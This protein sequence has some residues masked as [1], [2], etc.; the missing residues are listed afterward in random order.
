MLDDRLPGGA[1]ARRDGKGEPWAE[2][3]RLLGAG[4]QMLDLDAVEFEPDNVENRGKLVRTH[5]I[6]AFLER[7]ASL[8]A[9]RASHVTVS[10]YLCLA[11]I[12]ANWQPYPPRFFFVIGGAAPPWTLQELDIATGK[13]IAP[14]WCVPA[15]NVPE[16]QAKEALHQALAKV[17]RDSGIYDL[18]VR[19]REWLMMQDRN[20]V[21]P[22]KKWI[23]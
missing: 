11:R 16:A 19:L 1:K 17:W 5:A 15:L 3:H 22:S 8:D 10:V 18:R 6:V 12:V 20:F 4:W 7:K 13:E 2:A 21:Q 9:A 14:T 23:P